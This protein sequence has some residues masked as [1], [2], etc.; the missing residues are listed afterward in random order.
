MQTRRLPALDGRYWALILVASVLGTTFGDFISHLGLGHAGTFPPL[1]ILLAM[2]F[3]IERKTQHV[4][5][6]SYW[7][8]F[9]V[10]KTAALNLGDAFA[11]TPHLGKGGASVVFG[12]LLAACVFALRQPASLV[13]APNPGA[14]DGDRQAPTPDARYWLAMLIASSF[15]TTLGDFLADGI[16]LGV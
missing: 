6:V 7:L 11:R 2:I 12:F 16:G 13:A 3:V 1:I 15:G 4:S 14:L 9:I 8:P 5:V 10:T